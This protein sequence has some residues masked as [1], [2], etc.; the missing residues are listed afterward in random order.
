MRGRLIPR[1]RLSP[2]YINIATT[3]IQE[4]E[5]K[6]SWGNNTHM[7]KKRRKEMKAMA[8]RQ[9]DED[10]PPLRPQSLSHHVPGTPKRPVPS[11][12]FRKGSTVDTALLP[13]PKVLGFPPARRVQ[14]ARDFHDAL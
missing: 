1:N 6:K 3:L 4:N 8:K 7:P 2:R 9:N 12:P 13:G 5:T 10:P 14:W 11:N